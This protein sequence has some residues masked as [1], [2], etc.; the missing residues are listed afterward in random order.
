MDV[1]ALSRTTQAAPAMAAPV[2]ADTA[3]QNRQ[4]VQAVKALNKS[5][6]LSEDN[7]LEFQKDPDSKRWVIKVVNK[8]TGDVISQVPAEYVLRLADDLNKT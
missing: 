5:D 8:A 3:L 6:M 2:S 7:G 1:I 4:L